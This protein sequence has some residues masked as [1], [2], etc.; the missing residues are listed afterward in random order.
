MVRNVNQR[1]EECFSLRGITAAASVIDMGGSCLLPAGHS[2]AC[3]RCSVACERILYVV[4]WIL[5]CAVLLDS[6]GENL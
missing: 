2:V 1:G 6:H 5:N 3:V 4:Q